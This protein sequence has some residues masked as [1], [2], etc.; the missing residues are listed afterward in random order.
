MTLGNPVVQAQCDACEATENVPL[1]NIPAL[2]IHA[3]SSADV[4]QVLFSMGWEEE[5]GELYCPKCC[6]WDTKKGVDSEP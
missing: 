2:G 1:E 6:G 4:S 3:W 5:D